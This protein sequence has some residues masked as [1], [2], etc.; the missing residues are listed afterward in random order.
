GK[1]PI[2]D[3]D[4]LLCELISAE[5]AGKLTGEILA[6]ERQD[7]AG[8]N[9][10]LLRKVLKDATGQYTLRA[11]NP[12]Y[13]DIIVTDELRAQLR[14]SARLKIVLVPLAMMVGQPFMRQ[15]IPPL[16]GQDF[17]PGSRNS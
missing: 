2:R 1:S 8:D 17:N 11:N 9:Q 10:Y 6:I 15:D 13:A 12:D 14:T 5:S 7:E 4:Y 3:G 16:F